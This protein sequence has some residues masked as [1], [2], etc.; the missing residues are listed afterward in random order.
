MV[1]E[2]RLGV[3]Q[4]RGNFPDFFATQVH[5]WTDATLY[6]WFIWNLIAVK[7]EDTPTPSRPAPEAPGP[8]SPPQ[9]NENGTEQSSAHS[10]HAESERDDFGTIVTEVTTTLVTTRKKYRVDDV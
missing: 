4:Y 8:S 10:Q 5:L 1:L 7:V 3:E 6:P 2:P 9:Y